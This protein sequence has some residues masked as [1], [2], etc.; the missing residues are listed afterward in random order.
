M[1][2][3]FF[4]RTPFSKN[5]ETWILYFNKKKCA[6]PLYAFKS[7]AFLKN[8]IIL[9]KKLSISKEVESFFIN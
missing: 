8:Q 1:K 4:P 3:S 9:T 5:F 6:R 7:R 2:E